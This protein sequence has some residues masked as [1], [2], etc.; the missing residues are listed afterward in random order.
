MILIFSVLLEL[1]GKMKSA[2]GVA[3]PAQT[4]KSTSIKEKQALCESKIFTQ[5]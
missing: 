2:E 1:E 5:H 3:F 4:I